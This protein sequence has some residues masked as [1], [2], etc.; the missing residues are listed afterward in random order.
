[1]KNLGN[2]EILELVSLYHPTMIPFVTTI[3]PYPSYEETVKS[4]FLGVYI[5]DSNGLLVKKE[6]KTVDQLMGMLSSHRST[7]SIQDEQGMTSQKSSYPSF[8]NHRN[9]LILKY[10]IDE[11]Q[12]Y[13]FD[14]KIYFEGK[15]ITVA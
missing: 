8:M 7:A 5:N 3:I 1:M 14:M 13:N 2:S 15:T 6:P 11:E 10:K 12:N 4:P 9:R